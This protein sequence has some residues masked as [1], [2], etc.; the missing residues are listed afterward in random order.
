MRGCERGEKTY[1]VR[2]SVEDIVNSLF[3]T[4]SSFAERT[5]AE[6]HP[7]NFN[8]REDEDGHTVSVLKRQTNEE[9]H[10]KAN[11][12]SQDVEDK[13]LDIVENAATLFNSVEDG[14]KVIIGQNNICRLLGHVGASA[15]GNTDICALKTRAIVDTVAGHGNVSLTTMQSLNHAHLCAGSA[16]SH[17]ERQLRKVVNLL[18]RERIKVVGSRHQRSRHVRRK[19]LQLLVGG[20]DAD[21]L[22]NGARSLR[23]VA[24]EH[25][26]DDTCT[27]EGAHAG[28]GFGAGRVVNSNK[29]AEDEVVF[30]V[31]T[32]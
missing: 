8:R 11:V 17:H 23:V 24:S 10:D 32:R 5:G 9:R 2:R 26:H 14:G 15:H 29:T 16:S 1:I 21:V 6:K 13:L 28:L 18:V 4:E 31:T 7:Q 22:R 27:V 12:G 19:L 25:V 20:Q 3:E 30:K